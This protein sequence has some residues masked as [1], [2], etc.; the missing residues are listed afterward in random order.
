MPTLR[1]VALFRRRCGQFPVIT[2]RPSS[3]FEMCCKQGWQR[4][5]QD[6]RGDVSRPGAMS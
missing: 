4:P 1:G 2:G 5:A 6:E 3:L